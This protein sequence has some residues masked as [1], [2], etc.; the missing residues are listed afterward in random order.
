[1][2]RLPMNPIYLS[3]LTALLMA[4]CATETRT[5]ADIAR[6]RSALERD[7]RAYSG[8]YTT[9]T[10]GAGVNVNLMSN[11]SYRAE[12]WGCTD[13]PWGREM[14][15]WTPWEGHIELRRSD[16]SSPGKILAGKYRIGHSGK[17]TLLV[18]VNSGLQAVWP[19]HI[20]YPRKK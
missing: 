2:D 5:R 13:N 17:T 19:P 7:Y 9:F 6:E 12:G 4:G 8:R 15:E 1:M 14:G 3:L 18:P 10:K 20:L 16:S 11:G